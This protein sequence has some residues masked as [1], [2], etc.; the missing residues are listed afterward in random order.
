MTLLIGRPRRWLGYPVVILSKSNNT[1]QAD[2]T[3]WITPAVEQ[4]FHDFVTQGWAIGHA[5]RHG[6]EGYRD[7]APSPWRRFRAAS[8]AVPGGP[9]TRRGIR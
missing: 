5:L 2:K 1:S 3:P 7:P 8:G 6:R 4:A 9:R